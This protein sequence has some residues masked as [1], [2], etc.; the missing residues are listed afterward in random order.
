MTCRDI[1]TENPA[2]CAPNDAVAKVAQ[3]MQAEDVG[4]IPVVQDQASKRLIG[5]VTDRD[6]AIRVVAAGKD[7]MS[8]TVSE[9][10]SSDPVSCG[11]D[12]D[13]HKALEAMSRHQVRRIPIVDRN[14][15]VI[16]IIAQADVARNLRQADQTA[17]VVRDI[18]QPD[19]IDK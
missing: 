4:S 18:S 5:V 6:L 13:L 9:V 10:M 14:Q 7:S 19:G 12:D 1:M 15:M 17:E 16:G 8:T 11:P 3:L 2:C